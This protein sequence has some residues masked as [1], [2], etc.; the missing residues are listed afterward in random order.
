MKTSN[1]TTIKQTVAAARR[2]EKSAGFFLLDS[3]WT[4]PKEKS[5]FSFRSIQTDLYAKSYTYYCEINPPPKEVK[6]FLI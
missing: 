1:V 3:I 6:M 5:K 2:A 4:V